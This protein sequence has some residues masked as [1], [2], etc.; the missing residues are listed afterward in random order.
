[1]NSVDLIC[2]FQQ[3]VTAEERRLNDRTKFLKRIR[4]R[5]ACTTQQE[6]PATLIDLSR[7]G[8]Y[9]TTQSTDY[10]VGME[11]SLAM[12]DTG[13]QCTCEVVRVERLPNG[14]SG[15]GARILTW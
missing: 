10:H 4:V 8:L 6:E 7:T 14:R 12:P 11:V 3:A 15:V 2:T 1:V 9:F 13:S 5:A